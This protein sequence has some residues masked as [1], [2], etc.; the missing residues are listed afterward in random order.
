MVERRLRVLSEADHGPR[1]EAE[2]R[3]K[4]PLLGA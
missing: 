2:V 3:E 1:G 4:E